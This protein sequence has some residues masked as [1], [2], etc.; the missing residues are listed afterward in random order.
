MPFRRT[1]TQDELRQKL[2]PED[3]EQHATDYRPSRG[4]W[5]QPAPKPV[6]GARHAGSG[7]K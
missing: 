4:G 2:T 5:V 1:I 3:R 6:P 7:Q